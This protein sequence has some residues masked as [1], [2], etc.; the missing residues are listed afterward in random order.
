MAQRRVVR[1]P[2]RIYYISVVFLVRNHY[3]H[4]V[5]EL[6]TNDNTG[7]GLAATETPQVELLDGRVLV[8]PTIC[9]LA[10]NLR[11]Y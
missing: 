1:R 8:R 3:P 7:K 2:I 9:D 5:E 6:P 10:D 11:Y 4:Q